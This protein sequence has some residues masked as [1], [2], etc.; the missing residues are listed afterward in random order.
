MTESLRR[1]EDLRIKRET[2]K[3]TS[4]ALKEILENLSNSLP[5]AEQI[6]SSVKRAIIGTQLLQDTYF[7]IKKYLTKMIEK[8]SEFEDALIAENYVNIELRK[9][10]DCWENIYKIISPYRGYLRHSFI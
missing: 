1:L 6:S 4:D 8:A 5:H 3:D 2:K 7:S 9:L 10:K